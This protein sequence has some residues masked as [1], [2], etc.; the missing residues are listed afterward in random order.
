MQGQWINKNWSE[1]QRGM[2]KSL[3]SEMSHY[4][5][6]SSRLHEDFEQSW[7]RHELEDSANSQ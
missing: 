6:E 1:G 2:I 5:L 4:F 7:S 3:K